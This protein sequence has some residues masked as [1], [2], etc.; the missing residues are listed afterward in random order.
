MT[1][2]NGDKFEGIF[3]GC[4]VGSIDAVYTL[5]M[6]KKLA[7]VSSPQANGMSEDGPNYVGAGLEHT[8]S[9]EMKDVIDLA[10]DGV[11]FSDVTSKSANGVSSGFRT[12]ADISGNLAIRER[13]LQRWEPSTD[14]DVDLSLEGVSNGISGSATGGWDQF[15]ANAR[16]YGVKTSYDEDL[17]TTSIDRSNP[18][19]RQRLARAEKLAREI[20]SGSASNAHVAEERGQVIGDDSGMD[21]ED[22]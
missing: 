8:Q 10:C 2:S 14:M 5:S 13:N 16:M 9:F 12:D 19:Y 20:E 18:Q 15:E 7:S 11:S 1:T 17:Y 3:S 21:E 22:K 4:T 6:T